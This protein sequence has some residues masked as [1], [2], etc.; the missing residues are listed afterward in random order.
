MSFR[1]S[2]TGQFLHRNCP[3]NYNRTQK[4]CQTTQKETTKRTGAGNAPHCAC[5]AP[6]PIMRAREDCGRD[7][8][9]KCGARGGDRDRRQS[10]ARR[11]IDTFTHGPGAKTG[12]QV[13]PNAFQHCPAASS[14]FV[15]FSRKTVPPRVPPSRHS[16]R[17]HHSVQLTYRGP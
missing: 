8:D 14:A 13:P 17:R 12:P 15:V 6:R 7:F 3:S 16:A 11:F 10:P 2:Q 9:S 5:T 1:L 4:T